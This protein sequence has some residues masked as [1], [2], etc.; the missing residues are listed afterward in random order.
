MRCVWEAGEGFSAFSSSSMHVL[1]H[2]P[3]H[4]LGFGVFLM[5]Q[6]GNE[7]GLTEEDINDR[8]IQSPH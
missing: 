2:Y 1:M 6:G 8:A 4:H 3:L 7:A 5:A